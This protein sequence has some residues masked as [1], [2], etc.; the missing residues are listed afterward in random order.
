MIRRLLFVLIV[1]LAFGFYQCD[2]GGGSKPDFVKG[3][4][5]G[6]FPDLLKAPIKYKYPKDLKGDKKKGLAI[7]IQVKS[8][9]GKPSAG[10]CGACH[11]TPTRIK[12][13]KAVVGA[14][15]I[16][17]AFSSSH[18]RRWKKKGN[19]WLFQRIADA[20]WHVK[21]TTMPPTLPTKI[22]NKQDIVHVM[23]YLKSIKK[24]KRKKRRKKKRRRKRKR[25]RT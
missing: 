19:Q 14:G 24:S 21:D 4:P 12:G 13:K 1:G 20:R 23:A 11:A 6:I 16:G 17:P 5:D 15:N 2:G 22:L 25:R 8:K 3:G 9:K 10:N 7:F 18:A